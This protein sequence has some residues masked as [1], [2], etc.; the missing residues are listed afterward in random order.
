VRGKG[1]LNCPAEEAFA[2]AVT[3]LRANDAVAARKT[4]D[5]EQKEFKA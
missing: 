2:T 1:T 5:L 4:I 3:V